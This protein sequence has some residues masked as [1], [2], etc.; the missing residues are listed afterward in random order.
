MWFLFKFLYVLQ[1]S[2]SP[3]S[4][5]YVWKILTHLL[6][7]AKEVKMCRIGMVEYSKMLGTREHD[8]CKRH[9]TVH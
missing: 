5:A 6:S 2:S 1:I 8:G 3:P 4:G 9:I 7:K